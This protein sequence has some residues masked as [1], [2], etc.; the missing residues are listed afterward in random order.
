MRKRDI[1]G[2]KSGNKLIDGFGSGAV[3]LGE[4]GR[5]FMDI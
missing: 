3:G 4:R 1:W 2:E 5:V